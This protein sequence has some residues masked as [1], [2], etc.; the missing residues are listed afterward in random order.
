MAQKIINGK[1]LFQKINRIAKSKRRLA[2]FRTKKKIP[3]EALKARD[4]EFKPSKIKRR[5]KKMLLRM[6]SQ[7]DIDRDPVLLKFNTES[8]NPYHTKRRQSERI[9]MK[10]SL[11][12]TSDSSLGSYFVRDSAKAS[13]SSKGGDA[14]PPQFNFSD[15]YKI[16]TKLN[17]NAQYT[18]RS[19]TNTQTDTDSNSNSSLVHLTHD[20]PANR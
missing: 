14:L 11:L 12:N 6:E 20:S 18:D 15:V 4:M 1:Y 9:Y 5:S 10:D 7:E 8:K 13:Q 16:R 17:P 19:N 3:I 2:L